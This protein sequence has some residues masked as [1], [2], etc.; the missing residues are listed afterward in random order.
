MRNFVP[1]TNQPKVETPNSLDEFFGKNSE[2]GQTIE[3]FENDKSGEVGL[4]IGQE[5]AFSTRKKGRRVNYKFIENPT[6]PKN[7]GAD[8]RSGEDALSTI[9]QSTLVQFTVHKR[10][11]QRAEI[12]KKVGSPL[13]FDSQFNNPAPSAANISDDITRGNVQ[14]LQELA[15]LGIFPDDGNAFFAFEEAQNAARDPQEEA[16]QQ[17][18]A[19]A[20]LNQTA[21]GNPANLNLVDDIIGIDGAASR[22]LTDKQAQKFVEAV[23]Q[24]VRIIRANDEILE[25]IRM[26]IPGGLE[27][28]DSV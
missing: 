21:L 3:K 25:K 10:R 20:K 17:A 8:L 1:P 24:D 4:G 11:S 13:S 23:S 2:I 26:Y 5:E 14:N 19:D 18:A 15:A 6:Y 9:G 12:T 16:A 7:I 27:F 22:G 28:G